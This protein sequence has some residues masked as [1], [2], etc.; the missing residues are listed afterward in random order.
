MGECCF[1]RLWN[2]AA[3]CNGNIRS[4]MVR[5]A[6]GWMRDNR[7]A[8]LPRYGMYACYSKLFL[9]QKRR[10]EPR[11]RF[12]KHCL[13]CA[14]RA[15]EQNF[16]PPCRCNFQPA[17]RGL[18]SLDIRQINLRFGRLVGNR[19]FGHLLQRA[20]FY[21]RCFVAIARD[22]FWNKMR[23]HISK[24][25]RRVHFNSANKRGFARIPLRYKYF[26][27]IALARFFYKRKYTRD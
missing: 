1:T 10:E 23:N 25:I 7:V 14:G 4:G 2:R 27:K 22:V 3:A 9:N 12:R 19:G 11:K 13:T 6:D 15:P 5:G 8:E 18:L 16:V 24:R 26:F 21:K 20:L 17:L